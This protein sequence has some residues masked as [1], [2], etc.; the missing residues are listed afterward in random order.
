MALCRALIVLGGKIISELIPEALDLILV[1]ISL[2]GG[3]PSL[4]LHLDNET[5]RPHWNQHRAISILD[6]MH[7][8]FL[9]ESVPCNTSRVRAVHPTAVG[10][11]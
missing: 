10:E 1:P 8:S 2:Q 6:S 9:V 3:N 4:L 5:G 11:R 7:H